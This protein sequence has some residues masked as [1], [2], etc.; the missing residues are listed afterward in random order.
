MEVDAAGF[1]LGQGLH[2]VFTA[3]GLTPKVGLFSLGMAGYYGGLPTFDL[4]GLTSRSV[5]HQPL[6]QR[7]RPGHEKTATVGQILE[8]GVDLSMIPL[9]PPPYDALNRVEVGGA[10]LWLRAHRPELLD[11]LRPHGLVDLGRWMDAQPFN[12]E[13]A[14]VECTAWHLRESWFSVRDDAARRQRLVEVLQARDGE[15][16]RDVAL[17]L[18]PPAQRGWKPTVLFDFEHD[19]GWS[20]EGESQAWLVSQAPPPQQVPFGQRGRFLDTFTARGDAVQGALRSPPFTVPAGALTLRI[21]GGFS[22]STRVELWVDGAVV[23]VA[24]GC[25]SEWLGERAWDLHEFGGRTATLRIVDE[26]PG[27]WGHLLVDEVTAWN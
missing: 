11:T 17:M 27:G 1:R 22:P 12:E 14:R 16:A 15:L 2:E 3:R 19:E 10:W 13:R 23:R 20:R 25:D 18:E 5:A 9:A 6:L 7:G 8:A 24:R 21:G 26:N 4:R